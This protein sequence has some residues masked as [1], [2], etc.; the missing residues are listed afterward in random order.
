MKSALFGVGAML[1]AA[2]VPSPGM[3]PPLCTWNG[4]QVAC[5]TSTAPNYSPTQPSNYPSLHHYPPD[6]YYGPWDNSH[7]YRFGGE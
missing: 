1:A 4:V 6:W 2:A 5:A 7:G 3:V